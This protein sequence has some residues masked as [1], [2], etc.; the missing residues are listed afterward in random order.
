MS[1]IFNHWRRYFQFC[2]SRILPYWLH[3]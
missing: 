2:L 1:Y 3:I